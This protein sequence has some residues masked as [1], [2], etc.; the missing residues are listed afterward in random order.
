M[1]HH[2]NIVV[3]FDWD[4]ARLPRPAKLQ[5]TVRQGYFLGENTLEMETIMMPKIVRKKGYIVPPMILSLFRPR[6][7]FWKVHIEII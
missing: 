2:N 6:N 5:S 1:Q 7:E 4:K 3:Q